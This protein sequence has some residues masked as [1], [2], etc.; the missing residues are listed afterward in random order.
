M[1]TFAS[2]RER[3]Y[4]L[5]FCGQVL[6]LIGTCT[7]RPALQALV[8]DITGHDARWL[9]YVGVIPL[10]P[11]VLFSI[12]AGALVDRG[13]PHRVV[14]WTQALM[15]LGA[16]AMAMVV[17][18]G[19]EHLTPW[20]VVAY[21]AFSSSVFAVDAAARQSLVVELV[22]RERVTNAVA[23]NNSMFSVARFAGGLL[24]AVIVQSTNLGIA[25]CIGLN[26]ISFGFVIGGLLLMRLAPRPRDGSLEKPH[27]LGGIAYVRRTPA[28][29]ATLLVVVILSLFGFQISHL[30]P[31]Y[32]HKVWNTGDVGIGY[33]NAA[34][35]VGAFA[36]SLA[37][38][39]R[40]AGVHRGRL[41]VG[42]CVAAPVFLALFAS[43]LPLPVAMVALAA[44]GFVMT[45]AQAASNSLIQHTV[46]D[47]LRGR[48]MS[49]YTLSVLAAFPVGALFA[50]SLAGVVG[51]QMTTL[52]DCL[53]IVLFVVA[54]RVT[55]PSLREAR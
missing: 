32:A 26:A 37:L 45:Q 25:G 39:K 17:S 8:Y 18:F 29:R 10:L 33:L 35:G 34:A 14:V 52:L 23:L 21:A 19:H 30:L 46:P 4:L 36:G 55:H 24:F 16:A 48:V 12:P 41:V 27:P 22:P 11:S 28:V 44:A 43:G 20:H 51:A 3:N 54:I 5:F 6:S 15:M 40:S 1:G 13:N 50:G 47:E 7:E 49:L 38:A 42:Y 53:L 31:V 9:G 2:L